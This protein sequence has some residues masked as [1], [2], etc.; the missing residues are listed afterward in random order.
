M[1]KRDLKIITGTLIVVGTLLSILD[2]IYS[3]HYLLLRSSPEYPPL[4]RTIGWLLLL[5][6]P[7]IYITIDIIS[8]FKGRKDRK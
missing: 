4:L 3:P 2:K 8:Y 7:L 6:S 5:L 1:T